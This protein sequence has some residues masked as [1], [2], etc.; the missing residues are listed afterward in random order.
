MGEELG[1]E[2]WKPHSQ[3][4]RAG[5]PPIPRPILPSKWLGPSAHICLGLASFQAPL[6]LGPLSLPWQF[7]LPPASQ[8]RSLP[9]YCFPTGA[10][11]V[12]MPLG[13]CLRTIAQAVCLPRCPARRPSPILQGVAPG[14]PAP[15]L[16]DCPRSLGAPCRHSCGPEHCLW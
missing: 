14:P 5:P 13:P 1:P 10:G 11:G 7:P 4:P 8:T 12:N 15:G 3:L 9:Q 2:G 16:T 6:L